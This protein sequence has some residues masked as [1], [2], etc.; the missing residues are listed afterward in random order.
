MRIISFLIFSVALGLSVP[1]HAGIPIVFSDVSA[2]VFRFQFKLAEQGN[3]EAQY[4]VGEMYELGK[5]VPKDLE[6]ARQ[7]FEKA[8]AKE[9]LK[10]SY[11]ILYLDIKA[12]GMNAPRKDQVAV[13]R[14]EAA[15]GNADAQY[16]LGK[17]Y[18]SG[19]GVPKNLNN[20]ASWLNK[21]AFN[22]IPEAEHEAIAVEEEQARISDRSAK[23][24]AVAEEEARKKQEAE[25]KEKELAAAK[26]QKEK[27]A[28]QRE[29]AAKRE[30]ER[31][32]ASRREAEK[33]R[34]EQE[35][36]ESKAAAAEQEKLER[37]RAEKAKIVQV[38]KQ[39]E[40]KES[41]SFDADPCKG[42]KARF[43]ST[44]K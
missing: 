31:K 25:R 4:K 17:M 14:K 13:L 34:R 32:A 35:S 16:F 5:G 42:K 11:K 1:T 19:I 30:A 2:G 10:A 44:C 3:P 26:A 38:T 7:W 41:A 24:R 6:K 37:E 23:R 18:A 9:H 21:A 33:R 28:R 12:H 8:A 15:S 20:A 40:K 27:E 36:A 22:G 39:D 43:L 29:L